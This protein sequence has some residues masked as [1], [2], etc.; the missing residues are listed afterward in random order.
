MENS[1]ITAF[2]VGLRQISQIRDKK[3]GKVQHIITSNNYIPS[4]GTICEQAMSLPTM[5]I[6]LDE[7]SDFLGIVSDFSAQG[8]VMIC[9]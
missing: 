8:T 7:F 9:T 5:E 3:G 4:V 6:P 2:L 1:L